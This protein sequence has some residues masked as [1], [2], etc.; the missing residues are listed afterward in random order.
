MTGAADLWRGRRV[1]VVDDE[2]F[3]RVILSRM[4]A[5][6]GL[7]VVGSAGNGR[8]AVEKCTA[9]TPDIVTLDI[10]MPEMDGLA[11][12]RAI[13]AQQPEI[14]VLMSSSFSDKRVVAEAVRGGARGYLTKP[15]DL[16]SIREKLDLIYSGREPVA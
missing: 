16:A 8:E 15:F 14:R 1:L 12:L 7:E 5:E 6:L 13:V 9:L 4:L 11:A 2:K 10:S 3:I